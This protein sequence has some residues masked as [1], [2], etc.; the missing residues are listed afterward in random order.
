MEYAQAEQPQNVS[1]LWSPL[2]PYG[3]RLYVDKTRTIENVSEIVRAESV[4][5]TRNVVRFPFVRIRLK[6]YAYHDPSAHLQ[7]VDRV[8]G[9]LHVLQAVL[10]DNDI[11]GIVR[12]VVQRRMNGNLLMM[13]LSMPPGV[14]IHFHA[15]LLRATDVVKQKP[16]AAAAIEN[17]VRRS[18]VGLEFEQVRS[19]A[20]FANTLLRVVRI[21]LVAMSDDLVLLYSIHRKLSFCMWQ[22]SRIG[23][24]G[25]CAAASRC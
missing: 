11:K 2:V 25:L 24:P 17:A 20:N 1:I 22:R 13:I 23:M 6:R 5:V 10:A 9:I 18:N 19:S 16:S 15:D 14:R 7:L 12:N 8:V 3:L 4:Q 21:F